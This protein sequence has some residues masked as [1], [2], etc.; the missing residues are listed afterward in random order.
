[1]AADAANTS[2]TRGGIVMTSVQRSIFLSAVERYANLVLFFVA[3][4]VLSRL[5]T[6]NEFGIY[7]V[8]NAL[9][10]VVASSFQEF[11]GANY[12]IQKRELSG[13]SIRTA[14]TLMMAI[15][16]LIAAVLFVLADGLSRLFEQASLRNGVAVS[17]LNFLLVPFSGTVSALFRREMQFGRLAICN[18]A[19]G[20]AGAAVSI[21][22]AI[23]NFSYMAPIWG[24]IAQNAVLTAMLLIWYGDFN[25]FL[26]SLREYRDIVGFGLYSSGVSLINVFYSL[27]PQLF[28]AKIL[29]F[30][31]VGLYS[32]AIN[33][34]QM[35]DKFV[36]QVLNPV[37]MPAIVAQRRAGAD[38]KG[39]YLDA[40]QLLSAVQWPFL[41]F[42]AIMARSIILIWLGRNWLEIV[43]L[44]QLLCIANLALFAAS[45]SY[46]LLVVVGSVRD[47]LVSSFITLP[48]S[49]ILTLCAAFFGV[50][51][52]AAAALVTLPFQATVALYFIGRHLG[53]GPG[54]L[55]RTLLK[56]GLVAATTACGVV[57]CA[58][59]IELGM[60][61]PLA[62]L[63]LTFCSAALCWWFGLALTKHPL[64]YQLHRAAGGLAVMTPRLRPS[65]PAL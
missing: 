20:V 3:T 59:L 21:A 31:S 1:L 46:P 16:T 43:P 38:L 58:A 24:G 57:A 49:L 28:L 5:L 22:L 47:A 60:L 6:P 65:P 55:A 12:L 56:S 45:L 7:V 41:I 42:I 11:G 36:M 13:A 52:V 32:R 30:A 8:V 39:V 15:S 44:V 40:I 9:T 25:I 54:N 14:F 4:A 34:T 27:A 61:P 53:I 23:S 37:I 63:I 19:A 48:P 26:P 64:L 29:D 2:K 33:L 18:L 35:F 51:A 50:E 62:G 17:A 10:A